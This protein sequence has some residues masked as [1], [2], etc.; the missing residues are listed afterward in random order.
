MLFSLTNIKRRSV[1]DA[2]G[3]LAIVP[4]LLHGR[5]TLMLVEQAVSVFEQ[6][7]GGPRSEYD[8]KQLEAAMGD[9]RLGR[10]IEACLLTR[11]S[12]RQPQLDD[13]LLPE[14]AAALAERGLD[15]PPAL[16]AQLWDAANRRG[17][18]VLPQE[19][20]AFMS[21]LATE[22]GIPGAGG[23]IDALL[24]RD[25]EAAGVLTPAGERPSA[26]EIVRLYNRGV[27]KTLL[28][29][30]TRVRFLLAG[31]PGEAL[32]RAYFIAKRNGVLV[33]VE[34]VDKGFVLTLY[35]PEQAFG[36]AD[37]YGRRLADVSL[38]LLR[39]LLAG[40]AGV[41][42]LGTAQL[43]L[44]DRPY[45]FHLTAETLDRLEYAPK[46]A[47]GGRRVAE[48]RAAYSVGSAV[49]AADDDEG[50]AEPSFDSLV[51]AALYRG[52][53]SLERQGYTHGWQIQREPDPLLAP[54]VVLIPDF[55]FT[56]AD[57]RVVMEVAGF[58]S[59][60][61]KERKV[62]KLR[63]LAEHG[64]GAGLILAVPQD[65][66]PIFS[67]LPFPTIAYKKD[68][69][70]TD[71]L[72]LLDAHFGG[73]EEREETARSQFG[74]LQREAV[75]RGFVPEQEVAQTLE[76]Y[77]RSELLTLAAKLDGE[78]CRYVA[79]VGLLSV[80]AH[81]AVYS[82]LQAALSA[83]PEQ[84]LPLEQAGELAASAL[85]ASSVDIEALVQPRPDL[86]I[87]C[88]SLFEAYLAIVES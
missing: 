29:H 79:G 21:E 28:A 63:A 87:Q 55:A 11:F 38:S 49:E 9:Y 41:G 24:S 77:T 62:E 15:S 57:T 88:P 34:G 47:Q 44:H 12:F 7:V 46:E 80:Q 8:T 13:L 33:E 1:R 39:S 66:I 48:T 37:K 26:A 16:R 31:L 59:P 65:A 86:T 76:V 72:N 19:R 69:R 75:S 84:R 23:R 43:L 71:L 30:S 42:A 10:C 27:V 60:Q 17:G 81:D 85:A 78:G 54:G 58:W 61:Y 4:K 25:S 56:R 64:S 40:S 45:R 3:E 36:T 51:E 32:R 83:Q 20:A 53:R 35:G 70:P 14:E 52:F 67:G 22:W 5:A 82:A 73:R 50:Q 18:F 74:N 6:F 68:V 2:D